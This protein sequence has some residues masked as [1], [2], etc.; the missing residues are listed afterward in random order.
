[1][2]EQCTEHMQGAYAG[3]NASR[4][5]TDGRNGR[6]A[7]TEMVSHQPE[8]TSS[9]VM[10]TRTYEIAVCPVCSHDMPKGPA[11]K[12]RVY[13][14]LLCRNRGISIRMYGAA[15]QV[16]EVAVYRLL[17]GWQVASTRAEKIEAVRVLTHQGRSI[18]WI[19]DYLR[20]TTRSVER[21]RHVL[22]NYGKAA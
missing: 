6:N 16:D 22:A 15:G 2:S 17:E 18:A 3:S 1:M 9:S 5:C 7:L 4:I 8:T 14:S 13:C 12:P 21:Y 11:S 10:R 19:A 20:I